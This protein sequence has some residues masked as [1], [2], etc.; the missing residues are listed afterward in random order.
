[1]KRAINNI[2]ILFIVFVLSGGIVMAEKDADLKKKLTPG[3]YSVTQRGGTEPPFLN[4]YWDNKEQGIYVDIITG[5][6]LFSS[7]DKFDSGTG[8]PSFTR[9]IKKDSIVDRKDTSHGMSRTEVLSQKS[10][11]HL[12]HVFKDGSAPTGLRYCI[13]STALRFI[14]AQDMEKEGYKG[15]VVLFKGESV[16]QKT[17]IA[18]FGAGCFWGAEAAFSQVKGA[19]KTTAGFMGGAL[20]NPSYKDV[21]TNETGHAEVVQ[22]EYDPSLVSYEKLLDVFW[23]IH[24][25]TTLN[26]QGQD[27]GRQYRSVIFYHT[28]EQ[29]KTAQLIKKN[30]QESGKFSKPITTEIVP[31]QVFF[32]AEEYHQ[33]YYEKHGLKPACRMPFK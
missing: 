15:Y 26:R 5:E 21:C 4:K 25:P 31:A 7:Q 12:G 20:K 17:Q 32:K 30:W 6:P 18:T 24:D 22:I 29:E 9:P 28:P 16:K 14:P 11:S 13:N 27:I 2:L 10:N 1:M 19:V 23:S 8:W 33:K 3:Q